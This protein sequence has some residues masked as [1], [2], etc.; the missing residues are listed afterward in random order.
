MIK[1]RLRTTPWTSLLRARHVVSFLSHTKQ[2]DCD[3]S[4]AH[5]ICPD[6]IVIRKIYI[7]YPIRTHHG[8]AIYLWMQEVQNR[9][10]QSIGRNIS[11][12]RQRINKSQ[13]KNSVHVQNL[14]GWYW[15]F[16]VC[17]SVLT[18]IKKSMMILGPHGKDKKSTRYIKQI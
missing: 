9:F 15:R 14:H 5:C 7:R 2:N 6:A 10:I 11:K 3:I 1:L 8:Y 17:P 12:Y 16:F 18:K 4:S 13:V